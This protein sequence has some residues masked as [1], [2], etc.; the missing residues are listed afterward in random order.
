MVTSPL[1][2]SS[3]CVPLSFQGEGDSFKEEGLTLLL[4]TLILDGV[5]IIKRVQERLRLS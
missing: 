1:E 4:N 5:N 3:T 2:E